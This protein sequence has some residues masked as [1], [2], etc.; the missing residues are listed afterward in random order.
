[1]IPLTV[2][3]DGTPV[4]KPAPFVEPDEPVPTIARVMAI[5][6]SEEPGA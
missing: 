1:M 3:E 5:M 4:Q 2:N 6:F